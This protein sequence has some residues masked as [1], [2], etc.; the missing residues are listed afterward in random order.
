[1]TFVVWNADVREL[2]LAAEKRYRAD[3]GFEHMCSCVGQTSRVV[4]VGVRVDCA[5]PG[6]GRWGWY[7]NSELIEP[8]KGVA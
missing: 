7:P 8:A 5:S 3:R 6:C 1:M 2:L 4:G